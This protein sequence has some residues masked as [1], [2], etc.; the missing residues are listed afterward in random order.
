LEGEQTWRK[1]WFRLAFDS[2]RTSAWLLQSAGLNRY[3]AVFGHWMGIRRP[4]FLPRLLFLFWRRNDVAAIVAC[5]ET[6]VRGEKQSRMMRITTT[7]RRR[8]GLK[9]LG[10]GGGLDR[11]FLAAPLPAVLAVFAT[12]TALFFAFGYFWP[13]WRSGDMDIWMVYE[14]FLA[15]DGLRQEYFDH[16]GYLTILLLAKWFA[17]L[18]AVGALPICTL[19]DL[20]PVSDIVASEAAWTQAVRAGRILSLLLALGFLS[21]FGF[22]IQRLLRNASIAAVAIFVLAFSSGMMMEA[23]VIRTELI[24]AGCAY[25]A[26][27]IA[28]LAV[29]SSNLCRWALL[30]LAAMLSVLAILNKV[31]FLVLIMTFPMLIAVLAE[32][33]ERMNKPASHDKLHIIA[34]VLAL[35]AIAAVTLVWTTIVVGLQDPF[36]A[37][38][39]LIVIGTTV[40]VFQ[41]LICG[42]FV[43]WVFAFAVYHQQ[44][45]AT[46]VAAISAMLI[47][48]SLGLLVATLRFNVH[49]IV[50]VV[51]PIEQMLYFIPSITALVNAGQ[52][53]AAQ[54]FLGNLLSAAALWLARQTFILSPSPR[55]GLFLQWIV[56]GGAIFAWR[57]GER[58]T[59]TILIAWAVDFIGALRG[60]KI[61]YYL[62]SDPLIIFAAAW[63]LARCPLIQEH[64][65]TYRLGLV[66]LFSSV[67]LGLAEPVKHTFRRD[68]PL[69]FC[70]PHYPYTQRIERFSFC[71][72]S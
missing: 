70:I 65:W 56:L 10:Q 25:T 57:M 53:G 30:A 34:A 72:K 17:A 64:R 40:P 48:A 7:I 32:Y 28:L 13:Y 1:D 9:Q 29:R 36:I 27:L 44:R 43:L 3:D 11:L 5:S 66:A 22:L 35:L 58:R 54:S 26:L 8:L 59:A 42:W 16:P 18:H 20:P 60:G 68:V 51:N 2:I 52:S 55:P 38:I 4:E 24:G 23:R 41:A 15:N 69:D 63:L 14:A 39:R 12:F 46:V 6:L 67:V 62:V 49:N 71:P 47:G 45:L 21:I 37:R 19:S 33:P 50:T 31:Q 61:E